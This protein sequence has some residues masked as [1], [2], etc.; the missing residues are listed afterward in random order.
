METSSDLRFWLVTTDHL[1]K[2]LW[3]KDEEDFKAGM[4]F[5]A[6]LASGK[7][8]S[9][10]AFI[11]MS[12]HV[13]FILAG[14]RDQATAFIQEFKKKYSQYYSHKYKTK[15]LLRGNGIDIRELFLNDESFERAFA[16]V[17]MNC[18]AARI[19]LHPTGYPWG[20][21]DSFF[22]AT[23]PNGTPLGRISVRKNARLFHS[24][25][26]MPQTYFLTGSGYINPFSYVPV[27][28]VESVFRTPGRMNYFLQNSS[29]SKNLKESP[30]FS[31]QLVFSAMKDLCIS[32]FRKHSI[33]E[34]DENQQAGLLK[35]IRYRFSSDPKQ[36]ER[37]S[38]I[39]YGTITMLLELF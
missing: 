1:A 35:Q 9:V 4:N 18:V 26:Q 10:L 11:L 31:D 21:G 34:L 15:E 5:V 37:I 32:L 16:Y 17:Q 22:N 23:Q 7:T 13:H 30:S 27:S 14:S 20:T 29:K 36:L 33:S 2:R 12:N 19:C 39:P 28:F 38:G 3:F 8:V 6:L 25:I 24:T